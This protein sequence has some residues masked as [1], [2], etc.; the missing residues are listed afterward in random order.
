MV[1]GVKII[2]FTPLA[3]IQLEGVI[4]YIIQEFG[5]KTAEKFILLLETQLQKIA[6][7]KVFHKNFYKSKH[8]RYFIVNRKNYVLYREMKRSIHIV[9]VYGVKQNIGNI[10]S[11]YR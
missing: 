11:R 3:R 5:K 4:E 6:E 8:I 2:E 10:K 7:G 1:S 9:G